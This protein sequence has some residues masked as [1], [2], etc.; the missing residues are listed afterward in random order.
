MSIATRGRRFFLF[1]TLAPGDEGDEG[2]R[3]ERFVLRL[4][5]RLKRRTEPSPK[6]ECER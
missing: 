6:S 1:T 5:P 2:I 3:D 4:T